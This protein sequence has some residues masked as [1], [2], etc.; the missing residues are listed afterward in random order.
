MDHATLVFASV[1][2]VPSL[3]HTTPTPV[4]TPD[5][6]HT[7][8]GSSFGSPY[9]GHGGGEQHHSAKRN[10]AW[11]TA[12]RFLGLPKDVEHSGRSMRRTRDV[13]EALG[14]LLVGAGKSADGARAEDGLVGWYTNE[15]RL[16]FAKFVR[17]GL[18][19]LW[20]KVCRRF[21]PLLKNRA[22][23]CGVGDRIG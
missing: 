10:L 3:S 12:T 18:R 2:P 6:G 15:V 16:H 1:F 14:Y 20:G 5:L 7:A 13:D 21:G 11:S 17:P 19:E 4:A 9:V 22:L 8:P 23:T